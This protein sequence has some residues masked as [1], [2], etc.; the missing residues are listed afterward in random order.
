MFLAPPAPLRRPGT[1]GR[2]YPLLL[3]LWHLLP[4]QS[5]FPTGTPLWRLP[6]WDLC[7][8]LTSQDALT[9]RRTSRPREGEDVLV[10]LCCQAGR[11]ILGPRWDHS[12]LLGD[13]GRHKSGTGQQRLHRRRVVPDGQGNVLLE[14]G[15]QYHLGSSSDNKPGLGF[16]GY[17]D[18][19]YA[20]PDSNDTAPQV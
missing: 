13:A 6:C 20:R 8:P 17:S 5:T 19:G 2:L 3:L 15:T 14:T 1:I 16:V 18:R 10:S 7:S 12:S 9:Y 4:I 11:G